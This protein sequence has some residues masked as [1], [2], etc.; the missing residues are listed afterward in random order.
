MKAFEVEVKPHTLWNDIAA[1]SSPYE[2]LLHSAVVLA[3][4]QLC[5]SSNVIGSP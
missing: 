5:G 3:C 4:K 2:M 1:A